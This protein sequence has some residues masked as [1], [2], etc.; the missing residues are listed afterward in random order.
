MPS[1]SFRSSRW[2]SRGDLTNVLDSLF[3]FLV[4]AFT[5]PR[6]AFCKLRHQRTTKE[7]SIPEEPIAL[8]N[9]LS[10]GLP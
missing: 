4:L 6:P 5:K 7:T 3:H 8:I 9:S 1:L 2:K 10:K